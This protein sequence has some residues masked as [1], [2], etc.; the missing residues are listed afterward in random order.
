[1]QKTSERSSNAAG[2]PRRNA[3]APESPDAHAQQPIADAGGDIGYC[4]FIAADFLVRPATAAAD[5]L[6]AGAAHR[7]STID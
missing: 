2:T 4:E 6:P 3:P 7:I 5:E 1:M